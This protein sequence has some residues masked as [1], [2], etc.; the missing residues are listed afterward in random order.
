MCTGTCSPSL[1]SGVGRA[2]R[3]RLQERPGGGRRS[4]AWHHGAMTRRRMTVELDEELVDAAGEEAARTGRS[5]ND[6]IEDALREHFGR[7]RPSVVDAVWARNA[8]TPLSE[9]EA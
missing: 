9:D 6:V 3:G 5:D 8:T 4:P 1:N 7:P 2:G